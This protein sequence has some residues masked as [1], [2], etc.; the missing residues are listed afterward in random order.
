[1]RRTYQF[2]L[3]PT[4]EQVEKIEQTLHLCRWLYNSMLEQRKLAYKLWRISFTFYTQKKE[5]PKVKEEI[6]EF[7]EVYSQVLQDVCQRLDQTFQAFFRRLKKGEKAGDP[8]FQGKNRYD[9][10]TYPQSG[11]KLEGKYLTLSKIGT[12]RMKL[13]RQMDGKIKTCTIKRKNGRNLLCSIS[14]G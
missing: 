6:P 7:K 10:F 13:H 14:R 8:R 4:A 3:E 12:I 5:L 11:F 9:S 1:M 2:K